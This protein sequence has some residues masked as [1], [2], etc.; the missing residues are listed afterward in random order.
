MSQPHDDA[1]HLGDLFASFP[2][3]AQTVI[4][5]G[6]TT[7][8]GLIHI[9]AKGT[10][11]TARQWRSIIGGTIDE[12]RTNDHGVKYAQVRAGRVKVRVELVGEVAA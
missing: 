8:A 2:H 7:G 6:A 5:F 12:P 10:L 9:D 3:L 4:A 1:K 11:D